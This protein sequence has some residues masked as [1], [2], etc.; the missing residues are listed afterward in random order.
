MRLKKFTVRGYRGF[1]APLV[2]D[3]TARNYD[4]NTSLTSNGIVKNAMI[5]GPN[6]VGKSNFG[7]ALFDI[8]STLSDKDFFDDRAFQNEVFKSAYCNLDGE[9]LLAEFIYEFE[10]D[11]NFICYSYSKSDF[12]T[13][14]SEKLTVCGVAW[15]DWNFK[16]GQQTIE[17]DEFGILNI[18][19]TDNKM[20]VVRYLSKN[21]PKGRCPTLDC[22]VDFVNRMLW[23]RTLS[24]GNQYS[25]FTNGSS[26]LARPIYEQGKLPEFAEFLRKNGVS[27]DLAFEME[28]DKPIL[29]AYF[30]QRKRKIP[31]HGIAST[32][33]R[34]LELFFFWEI[35]ALN[36]VSLL[37]VDELDAFFHYESAEIVL[38][39]LNNLPC[40][41][42]VTSHN[43]YLMSN[44]L[45]R[46]DCC[47]LMSSGKMTPLC[48]ATDKEIRKAHN[49]AKMYVNGAFNG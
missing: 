7:Y 35:T 44:E 41:V 24:D 40:Q 37:F 34:A 1:N 26:S 8:V 36:R 42:V 20:S 27:F 43:T 16:T 28:N 14:V 45:T 49:L 33:T 15:L 47:Y 32:G 4:Y 18:E 25:G 2:M 11:G 13:F 10:L 9:Q 21:V 17:R 31:F 6:G 39:A 19:L 3:F 38:K 46:P 30:S 12:Q 5:Y 29:Y 22:L 48:D 23:Y